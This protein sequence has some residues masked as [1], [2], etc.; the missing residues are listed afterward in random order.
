MLIKKD[1]A[2][3]KSNSPACVVWEYHFPSKKLGFATTKMNGRYPGAG[4][5]VNEKV[6]EIFYVISGKGLIH[7][8]KGKFL[9]EEGDCFF[10]DKG[11]HYW[12]EA[13][14][15]FLTVSTAPAWFK[16]QYNHNI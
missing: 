16:T 2:N 9:M 10:L 6:D 4:K 11:E 5:M 14:N 13:E 7:L 8:G 12:I 1:K 3:K 15:L